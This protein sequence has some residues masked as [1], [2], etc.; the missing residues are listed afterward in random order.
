MVKK[1]SNHKSRRNRSYRRRNRSRRHSPT[2]KSHDLMNMFGG[3]NEDELKSE[4]ID[5]N[6]EATSEGEGAKVKAI[7][8]WIARR[9]HGERQSANSHWGYFVYRKGDDR[10]PGKSSSDEKIFCV[11]LIKWDKTRIMKNYVPI[12]LKM[13]DG[14]ADELKDLEL[15]GDEFIQMSCETTALAES[16]AIYESEKAEA[17]L[18]ALRKSP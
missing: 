12:G 4:Q 14:V 9:M 7:R 15:S 11:K 17:R 16:R 6:A 18:E 2:K 8:N 13:K 1:S 5:L 3:K 10:K